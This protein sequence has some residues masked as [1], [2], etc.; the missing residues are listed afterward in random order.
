M[1]SHTDSGTGG[2]FRLVGKMNERGHF[3][4]EP[5]TLTV[6]MCYYIVRSWLDANRK[7]CDRMTHL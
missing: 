4:G 6:M 1:I 3:A 5:D 7:T 2:N